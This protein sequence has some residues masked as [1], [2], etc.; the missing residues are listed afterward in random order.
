MMVP[1]T[2]QGDGSGSGCIGT[3]L[4]KLFSV[5]ELNYRRL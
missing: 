1:R 3:Y 2:P 4:Y 5:D